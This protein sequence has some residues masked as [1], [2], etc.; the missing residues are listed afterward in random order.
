MLEDLDIPIKILEN[1]GSER[2]HS[3][4]MFAMHEA[5]PG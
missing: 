3:C 2:W 1:M 4:S 5:D